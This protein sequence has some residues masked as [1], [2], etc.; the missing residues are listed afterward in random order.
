MTRIDGFYYT[1]DY[2][3]SDRHYQKIFVRC[4]RYWNHEQIETYFI[5]NIE[6]N[7]VR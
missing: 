4:I 1:L 5:E 6:T 7:N 3:D 2:K